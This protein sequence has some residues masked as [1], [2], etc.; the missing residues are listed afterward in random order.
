METVDEEFLQAALDVIDHNHKANTPW[1]CYFTP[2][3]MLV[4]TY[5]KPESRA[6]RASAPILELELDGYVRQQLKTLDDVGIANG[7]IA[8]FTSDNSA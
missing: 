1:F 8:V 2:T 7:T 3:R 4:W 5:L 6:I